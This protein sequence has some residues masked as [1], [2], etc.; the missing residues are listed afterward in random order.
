[1]KTKEFFA[2]VYRTMFE[3]V[4]GTRES[5]GDF[6]LLCDFMSHIDWLFELVNN[7]GSTYRKMV[8]KAETD[9]ARVER[10]VAKCRRALGYYL[11]YCHRAYQVNTW[12]PLATMTT[13]DLF[14]VANVVDEVCAEFDRLRTAS[15]Q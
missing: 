4:F 10:Q 8:L 2:V 7:D 11:S 6:R 5:E 15:N 13:N 12:M 9:S 14:Q 1:M 3:G